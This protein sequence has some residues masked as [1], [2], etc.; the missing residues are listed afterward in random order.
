MILIE[1]EFQEL[2]SNLYKPLLLFVPTKIFPKNALEF[3]AKEIQDQLFDVLMLI[4]E[5]GAAYKIENEPILYTI[6]QKK[7]LLEAAV[8]KIFEIKGQLKAQQFDFF[9]QRYLTEVDAYLFITEWL[10]SNRMLCKEIKNTEV[11]QS[12]AY[13]YEYLKQ[14]LEDLKQHCLEVK[15][16]IEKESTAI[17]D[18]IKNDIPELK[19]LLSSKQLNLKETE[20]EP[21]VPTSKIK[22]AK[23]KKQKPSR[24]SAQEA[25]EYLLKTVFN[26]DLNKVEHNG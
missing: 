21:Q 12:L 1:K 17:L 15:K 4:K 10:Y 13:Q 19:T 18:F 9:I 11:D 14:H 25:E 6:L 26:V 7:T 2:R 16:P 20:K 8:F 24:M 23:K 22:T 3:V 5:D